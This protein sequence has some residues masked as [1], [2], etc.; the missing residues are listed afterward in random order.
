MR[1]KIPAT[2]ANVGCGYDT[3]GMALGYYNYIICREAESA[4][5]EIVGHGAKY[6]PRDERNLVL[7]SAQALCDAVGSGPLKLAFT[8]YNN[9]PLSRGMGSSSAAIVGGLTAA[10]YMLGQPMDTAALLHMA[11]S[12]E[13]HA[14][15]VAPALLGGFTINVQEGGLRTRRLKIPG[16]LRAVLAV[17]DFPLSTKKARAIMPKWVELADAVYNVSHAAW[18]AVALAGGD[19]AGFGEMLKDRL[20][21][22]YR[23]A[24]IPGAT[25]VIEAAATA[26]ALGCVI[27]G[28]G[29][30]MIAF[31]KGNKTLA[32]SIG[33]AM[34]QAFAAHQVEARIMRVAMDNTGTQIEA[35]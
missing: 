13:G 4:S 17:P 15:N 21:Q 28:S 10:N 24:L 27:S 18:L 5:I 12:I 11:A 35:G 3:F 16:A 1:V 7:R 8:A 22:P 19:L 29:P 25:D 30:A 26:G 33:M 2:T 6:L 14:D 9:I 32:Q 23:C 31:Y 20:H 34:K